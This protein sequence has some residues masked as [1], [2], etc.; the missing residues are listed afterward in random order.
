MPPSATPA[1]SVKHIVAHALMSMNAQSAVIT[2]TSHQVE[3]ARRSVQTTSLSLAVAK[4]DGPARPANAIAISASQP[5]CAQSATT[6]CTWMRMATVSKH[7]LMVSTM[8]VWK[9]EGGPAK[10][11]MPPV[12]NAAAGMCAWSALIRCISLR[13]APAKPNVRIATITMVLEISADPVPYV[14]RIAAS[15]LMRTR[16]QSAA[17]LH[18]LH[19]MI[20][21][22]VTALS[23]TM[24]MAQ[25]MW[26]GCA[27]NAPTTVRNAPANQYVWCVA[28]RSTWIRR[29][30]LAR[31]YV[32]MATLQMLAITW[33]LAAHVRGAHPH[34]ILATP[35][36]IAE[37]ARTPRFLL[38]ATRAKSFVRLRSIP[39]SQVTLVVYVYV[40]QT[41]AMH[42][43]TKRFVHSARCISTS[44]H[45]ETAVRAV[46]LVTMQSLDTVDSAAL[47]RCAQRIAASAQVQMFAQS[48]GTQ[49]S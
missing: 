46:Q 48:A 16:A 45:L 3:I 38:Q 11:V 13:T 29:A 5:H 4:Q 18:T 35:H 7:V 28:M 21:V 1:K 39:M 8:M 31:H 17:T 10:N 44:R 30:P 25:S 2:S 41:T 6:Q 32:L 34:A 20:G 33:S 42:A 47:V 49:H 14:P 40:A 23:A 27:I 37:S 26:A 43:M 24:S 19:R 15:V 36:L 9:T 12:Q 22:I